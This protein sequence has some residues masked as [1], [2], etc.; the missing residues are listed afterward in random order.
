MTNTNSLG[1][2]TADKSVDL[3]W[4]VGAQWDDGDH[5]DE[6]IEKGIWI[7]GYED[8]FLNDVNSINVG[9]KI[10]IKST[11]TQKNNLPFNINNGTA[12]LMI[13]KVVG[14][15]TENKGDG[16]HLIVE[17]EKPFEKPKRWYF[18]TKRPTLCKVERRKDDWTCGALLDFTFKGQP[19]DYD[20][21][22]AMNYWKNKYNLENS[23]AAKEEEDNPIEYPEDYQKYLTQLLNGYNLVLT[24]APGTGK[25]YLAHELADE[26]DAEI[27]F[28]QFHPSYDYTD[29][30]EG[31]RPV[32]TDDSG[33]IKFARMDGVFKAFCKRAL[34][35]LTES[36]KSKA[37]REEEL[38]IQDKIDDFLEDAITN[39]T[40]FRTV[41]GTSFKI[42]DSNQTD[43]KVHADNEIVTGLT[44]KINVIEDLLTQNVNLNAVKDI[45]EHYHRKY[46]TQQ[47]SYIYVIV[48]QIR[49]MKSTKLIAD[50][51]E[52]VKEKKFVFIID[53]INRGDLSK[54]FGELFFAIDKGYRKDKHPISTQY[55]NL[56]DETDIFKDGFFVPSNVYILAP[57]NDIDRS[58]DTLDFA[59]RRRFSWME[60]TA[61][62]SARMMN[63]DDNVV[64]TMRRVNEAIRKTEGLGRY[65]ELGGAYFLDKMSDKERW[66][67]HIEGLLRDYLRGIDWDG[68]KLE[69]IKNAY[70]NISEEDE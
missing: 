7:N 10:A 64:E 68:K 19:Q 12:S 4:Y 69:T 57:M 11:C 30:V 60:V 63:L 67:I 65:Y 22:L 31:L 44:L 6:F 3:C 18:S 15:V 26:L 23:S 37:Q 27:G 51:A 52:I 49:Q 8:K 56:V 25:T 46:G 41:T 9:E 70:F 36:R 38:S 5:T 58:V 62:D 35:N 32:G 20:R 34:A 61:E 2:Q 17:W 55:Q 16:R 48:E 50:R 54:I 39:G 66:D 40:E 42:I 28:V 43:I 21:F 24:G 47:D 14:T 59:M 53:E 29:F 33:N 45:R 1:G 13:I